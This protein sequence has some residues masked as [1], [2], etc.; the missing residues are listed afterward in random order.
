[1]ATRKLNRPTVT[2][3]GAS[4]GSSTFQYVRSQEAP[5]M[6][7]DSSSSAPIWNSDVLKVWVLMGAARRTKATAM[8]AT[9]PYSTVRS[10]VASNSHSTPRL[11]STP[12]TAH[13]SHT[14]VSISW[15]ASERWRTSTYATSE[16]RPM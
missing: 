16:Y 4:S 6:R 12:G 5:L 7:A 15:A 2:A 13:G 1:M 14:S 11:I 9:L 8:P 10:G 3:E